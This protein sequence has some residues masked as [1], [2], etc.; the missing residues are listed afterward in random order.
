MNHFTNH[1]NLE[2]QDGIYEFVKDSFV[3]N[4]TIKIALLRD[5][6]TLASYMLTLNHEI[7]SKDIINLAIDH[8]CLD[9]LKKVWTG[10]F[11]V[12]DAV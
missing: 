10:N 11:E 5:H 7:I 6:D 12:K 4:R 9:F 8:N 1:H 3:L 2:N